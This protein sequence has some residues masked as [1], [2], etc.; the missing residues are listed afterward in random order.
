MKLRLA[1]LSA[2]CLLALTLSACENTA[3]E[4]PTAEGTEPER[5]GQASLEAFIRDEDGETQ[6]YDDEG[7]VFEL[8][9]EPSSAASDFAFEGKWYLDGDLSKAY[10]ELTGDAYALYV[11]DLE[12][13]SGGYRISTGDG[14]T[15]ITFGEDMFAD[16]GY[17]APNLLLF[18][19]S[20]GFDEKVYIQ[21]SAVGMPELAEAKLWVHL[22]S[23]DWRFIAE[24]D[25]HTLNMHNNGG[26]DYRITTPDEEEGAYSSATVDSG[27]WELAGG[28]LT[29]MW[30]D[31]SEEACGLTGNT[32]TVDSLGMTFANGKPLEGRLE[33][34][35]GSYFSET[36][37]EIYVSKSILENRISVSLY[38]NDD[39]GSMYSSGG[40]K[41]SVDAGSAAD[42]YIALR[43][44]GDRVTVEAL[45]QQFE[46][47]AGIYAREQP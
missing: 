27:Q 12:Y 45:D 16:T 26:F 5:G 25:Q 46:G 23:S 15:A 29:L 32:I 14:V 35:Y 44:D 11:D 34:W 9:K 10:Y 2:M 6:L 4:P 41:L 13:G 42:D 20:D 37:A 7:D 39:I 28:S 22:V 21:E 33:N 24:D 38:L 43:L 47:Y 8:G 30:S 19:V 36:G 18:C 1:F 3:I 40:I 17:F 31:G